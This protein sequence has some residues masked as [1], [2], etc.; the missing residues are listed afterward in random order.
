MDLVRQ[1]KTANTIVEQT[2][3]EL[4]SG[5][6]HPFAIASALFN[7]AGALWRETLTS[8]PDRRK[9]VLHAAEVA[10]TGRPQPLT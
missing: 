5:S 3:A 6:C 9:V 7:A 10:I 2:V 4:R 1:Q 8:E